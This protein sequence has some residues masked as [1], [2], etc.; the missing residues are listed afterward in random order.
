MVTGIGYDGTPNAA[1]FPPNEHRI[2]VADQDNYEN[3]SVNVDLS[4]ANPGIT[5]TFASGLPY[6]V[7]LT[8]RQING[9][10]TYALTGTI[11]WDACSDDIP[12]AC[13]L[14]VRLDGTAPSGDLSRITLTWTVRKKNAIPIFIVPPPTTLMC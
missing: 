3:D 13:P 2:S 12:G 6:G 10:P 14:S 9:V 7:T 1:C 4:S 5:F 8:S 11:A